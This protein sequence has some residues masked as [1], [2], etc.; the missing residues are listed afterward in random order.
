[1]VPGH[2]YALFSA[3]MVNLIPVYDVAGLGRSYVNAR[4]ESDT[5][6][7]LDLTDRLFEEKVSVPC[8]IGK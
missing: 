3:I 4:M 7:D 5:Q 6:A 8:M 2:T 1:M